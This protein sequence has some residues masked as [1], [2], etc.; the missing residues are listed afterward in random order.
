MKRIVLTGGGTAGHVYPALALIPYLKE[1]EIF[2]IGS[3]GMEKEILKK[4]KNIKYYEIESVKLIRKLT[5]K[6]LAIPFKLFKGIKQAKNVLKEINPDV[7]FSKGGFVSVPVVLAGKKLGIPIVSHESDLSM[8]LAN[9]II[10][11]RC[12]VMCTTF[13]QTSKKSLKCVW[14]GQPIRNDLLNGNPV[15]IKS[16]FP[17]NS[18]PFL[19]IIGGS[20]GAKFINEKIWE[21]IDELTKFFNI[22]HII[23]KQNTPIE[24][25][26]NNYIQLQF[27]NNIGDLYSSADI[28]LSR[29]GS[30]VINELLVLKKPMLLIPL[31]KQCSRG[32]QIENANLFKELGYCEIIEEEDYSSEKLLEMLIKTQKNALFYTNNMKKS[33]ANEANKKIVEI[34]NNLAKK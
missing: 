15:N 17:S 7:I 19:L 28:V 32:D 10:L 25:S 16:K 33:T 30:G 27:A 2:Y 31:S 11:K 12:D 34:I 18:K 24:T 3:S 20:L 6:N 13:M 4:E 21:N 22:I 9:K 1:Y 29:A 5:L 14:T 8:G 26:H 23:G